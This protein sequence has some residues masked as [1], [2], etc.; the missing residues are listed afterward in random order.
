MVSLFFSMLYIQVWNA[1]NS[2]QLMFINKFGGGGLMERRKKYDPPSIA[3]LASWWNDVICPHDQYKLLVFVLGPRDCASWPD[4][5]MACHQAAPYNNNSPCFSSVPCCF[6]FLFQILYR[7]TLFK[8]H[9]VQLGS[10]LC[11]DRLHSPSYID[12]RLT[13]LTHTKRL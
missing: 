9:I 7:S 2:W 8:N 3:V 10:I 4:R 11:Q 6:S 12:G 5:F 13:A 1:R